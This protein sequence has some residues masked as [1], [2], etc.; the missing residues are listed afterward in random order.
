MSTIYLATNLIPS[1]TWG[2]LQLVRD[3][4]EI[5]V[6]APDSVILGSWGVLPAS[7]SHSS[8]TPNYQVSGKY[9]STAINFGEV[10]N[11]D[12]WNV[13]VKLRDQFALQDIDYDTDQNSN[14]YINTLLDMVGI[15]I[16]AHIA[17]A[18]PADV[19]GGFPGISTNVMFNDEAFSINVDLTNGANFLS[20][21]NADDTVNGLDGN[22]SIGTWDGDDSIDGG[23]GNDFLNG[24]EGNDTL[25]GGAGDDYL[26]G[27]KGTDS[28]YLGGSDTIVDKGD[29]DRIYFG[30]SA[31]TGT[32]TEAGNGEYTLNGK[33]LIRSGNDL[34]I[35]DGNDTVT[36]KGWADGDYGIEL[37]NESDDDEGE[38]N[39]EISSALD[40]LVILSPIALDLN[41]SGF[42]ETVPWW[43][44]D[45]YFD[46]DNDGFV[47]DVA[48]LQP[49][50]GWLAMD[51]NGD[52]VINNQNELFGNSDEL[53]AY[54]KLALLNTNDSGSSESVIDAAD[55]EWNNL[56]VWI[57][58]D[59]NGES[60]ASELYTMDALNITELSLELLGSASSTFVRNGQTYLSKDIFLQT[61][62]PDAWYRGEP[63]E[64]DA[65]ALLLPA[66]RGYG[67]VKSMEYALSESSA[68]MTSMQDLDSL[69]LTQLDQYIEKL[70]EVISEW[71]GVSGIDRTGLREHT[72]A[73]Q[74]AV[75]EA[76]RGDGVSYYEDT[77][78]LNILSDYRISA[79]YGVLAG[80]LSTRF[81][82]QG[83]L[84]EVFGDPDYHYPTDSLHFSIGYETIL[85]NA[86][87]LEPQNSADK[88]VYWSEI[89]RTLIEYAGDFGLSKGAIK[90]AANDTAGYNIE[91]IN[92]SGHYLEGHDSDDILKGNDS[93]DYI[94]G[95]EGDDT[96]TGGQGF[97]RLFG[98]LGSDTYYYSFGDGED[99]IREFDVSAD[100][101][102][103]VLIDIDPSDVYFRNVRVFETGT[104]ASGSEPWGIQ[105][106]VSD[107]G[108]ITWYNDD[109]M[110]EVHF[111]DGTIFNVDSD[112]FAKAVEGTSG[113][114]NI[115]IGTNGVNVADGLAGND[116]LTGYIIND[117][118]DGGNGDDL[119]LGD[120]GNDLLDGGSDADTLDGGADRDTLTGGTGS[121]VFKF[122]D[123]T[124]STASGGQDSITD[125]VVG[126]DKIDLS[127]LDFD[128]LVSGT[129]S[130][131]E[132]RLSYSSSSNRTYVRS[133]Q[134]DFEFYLNGDYTVSLTNADFLFDASS[135]QI[136]NGTGSA[137]TI[138]GTS[139]DDTISTTGGHDSINAGD[140]NDNVTAGSGNDTVYGEGGNDTISGNSD[141]DILNGDAGNDSLI[142]SSGSD[143]LNGGSGEDTL[144]GD[145]G[146]DSLSGGDGKDSLKGGDGDDTV[147]GNSGND[148]IEGGKG[149][150]TLDGDDGD[151]EIDGNTNN[152]SL[153]GGTG[154]DTLFGSAGNDTLN[155]GIGEDSLLGG[156]GTDIINGGSE[157]DYLDGDDGGDDLFGDGGNDTLNGSTGKDDMWGGVGAD[158]FLF[159]QLTDSL[160]T[161]PDRIKDFEDGI[162]LI[163]LSDLGFTGIQSGAAFGT[164]LG[165][166]QTS[167]KTTISDTGT[168]ELI[169]EN[170]DITLTASD[171]IFVD[172]FSRFTGTSS[173]DVLYGT[174]AP[175]LIEGLTGEDTLF[176]DA[177]NDTLLGGNDA[178]ELVSG[179]DND[180]ADGGDGNDTI[181]GEDGNDSLTGGEGNDDIVGGTGHDFI[182]GGSGN[183]NIFVSDGGNNTI[184]GGQ[185]YDYILLGAGADTIVINNISESALSNNTAEYV[186]NFTNGI[187]VYDLS[188][189]G[190][191]GFGDLTVNDYGSWTQI[192]NGDF[193]IGFE[194][195]SYSFTAT[196]FIFS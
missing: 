120:D 161:N 68:L 72:D 63:S 93:F 35:E 47:E 61:N 37:E 64:I 53:L 119:L 115:R 17:Q 67:D 196:D 118:L 39:E 95:G 176:G 143:T 148:T 102:T 82:A 109:A 6:Q 26:E 181:F 185:G 33:T 138:T 177:G 31:F 18:T 87:Q 122:S 75:L 5:E 183:D 28:F 191:S 105:V 86:T 19:T 123:L 99:R 190:F 27:G 16:S 156:T 129:T 10:T 187:D 155:G 133:D 100:T 113:D 71:A 194:G 38:P 192:T 184:T 70:D 40:G 180:F 96:I 195:S 58:A 49:D 11:D 97:D 144:T 90:N 14:S 112:V 57:D 44:N 167:S 159:D 162:D 110:D 24:G 124:H 104:T 66:S 160:N 65:A 128:A 85:N 139:G 132:L 1:T 114:D 36:L 125:F 83:A 7:R 52:G 151:D 101:N 98:D 188:A 89:A 62:Q 69:S 140:G 173:D 20:T 111:A 42:I 141:D 94:D 22:D 127:G 152:D 91:L 182:L 135:G 13:L 172:S 164:V 54:E 165:Y 131:G 60:A 8:T 107:G 23:A 108:S 117:T 80:A 81:I 142:G 12:A 29:T 34:T 30:S 150:D 169:I 179:A 41:G 73:R 45:V 116:T 166:T 84:G 178:D 147:S 77:D 79:E 157:D 174:S 103:L 158:I 25:D 136:I 145:S 46:I 189:L 32:A 137:D 153:T 3:D 163:Q 146:N 193:A 149:A 21:G 56:R 9:A 130:A 106:F 4:N 59:Q 88:D 154:D 92:L 121:D 126:D 50:E 175:N 76:F 78:I 168:F 55:A 170:G 48:W 43:D 171:F 15:S 186:T 134:S 2:H 74:V 51:Y